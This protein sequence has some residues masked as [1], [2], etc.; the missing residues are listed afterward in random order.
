M[1]PR[2]PSGHTRADRR[3]DI[4][5]PAA[6]RRSNH[7]PASPVPASHAPGSPPRLRERTADADAA[8]DADLCGASRT[9]R[10][11][12]QSTQIMTLPQVTSPMAIALPLGEKTTEAG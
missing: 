4:C 5:A 6:R 9:N 11:D 12:A 3:A 7:V 8:A 2:H 1:A 10:A